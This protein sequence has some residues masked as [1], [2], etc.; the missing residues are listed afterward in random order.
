M[1]N[2]LSNKYL[3]EKGFDPG[4][5]QGFNARVKHYPN[6]DHYTVFNY[7]AFSK[8]ARYVSDPNEE[9]FGDR[10]KKNEKPSSP[11]TKLEG[12]RSD[13]VHR[14]KSKVFDIAYL[15]KFS[16][17]VTLTFNGSIHSRTD[18]KAILHTVQNYTRNLRKYDRSISYLFIPEYHADKTAIHLHGLISFSDRLCLTP[19]G[20]FFKDRPVYNL[21]SW[22][23]GF[24]T[25]I[26]L[27]NNRL[28]VA[29]YIT[30]Y[31]TKDVHKIFGNIYLA[32]NVKR[33]VPEEYTYINYSDFLG[34]EYDIVDGI[35][36]KYME[37][38]NDH[39]L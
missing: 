32:G 35:S 38:Y 1:V 29:K 5:D 10:Y 15:N 25:A 20:H 37:V 3:T 30:K 19:S 17:F 39:Q 12:M 24:S 6:F 4:Q 27:D 34:V 9:I 13:S 14:A 21:L 28:A 26:E 31:V 7:D 36:V 16:Y 8:K 33:D 18:A 22:S 23:W 11:S 2:L